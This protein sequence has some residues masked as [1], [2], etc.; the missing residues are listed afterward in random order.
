MNHG[1][2]LEHT[3]PARR[4]QQ[5]HGLL[6]RCRPQLAEEGEEGGCG[7]QVRLRRLVQAGEGGQGQGHR[8]QVGGRRGEQTERAAGA[9][10][11]GPLCP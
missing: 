7:E 6:S 11:E 3:Q 2:G 4:P 1:N 9:C 8:R 5:Q 10:W